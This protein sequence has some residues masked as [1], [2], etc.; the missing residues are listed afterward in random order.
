MYADRVAASGRSIKERLNGNTIDDSGRRRQITGKRPRQD[1]D[2]WQHD[3]YKDDE[4]QVSNHRIGTKDLRLKLQKKSV[5]KAIHSG[6]GTVS[7]IR[8]LREKLSGTIYS[9]SGNTDPSKPKP[10]LEGSKRA[11]TN[12]IT[13]RARISALIDA[14]EP[15]TKRVA[16][17]VPTKKTQQK[18]ESVDSF[19]QSLG[20]EK[21][22]ITF[23]AEEVD[24]TALL[25]MTDGDL[26]A[27]GI[28]MGP[29]K[30]ILLVLES[31]D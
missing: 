11:R 4:P 18:A 16:S 17:S 27:L 7:G 20:L 22:S 3:L 24:M 26:K 9:Q 29:R 31:K 2:K 15:E 21:Y 10:V 13:S 25:H 19:L 30:K 8:D 6:I 14:P 5:Q 23:E 1:D 28:P 12:A